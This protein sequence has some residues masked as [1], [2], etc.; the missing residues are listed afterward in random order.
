MQ[1]LANC[2][3][4]L[5]GNDQPIPHYVLMSKEDETAEIHPANR[6]GVD[7]PIFITDLQTVVRCRV[8]CSVHST[9]KQHLYKTDCAFFGM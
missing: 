3:D 5:V 8:F 7:R 9:Y 4:A 6:R 1:L 2:G